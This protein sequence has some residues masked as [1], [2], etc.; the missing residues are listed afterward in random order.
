MGRSDSLL[1]FSPRFVF[2]GLA[3]P[4]FAPVLR[5]ADPTPTGNQELFVRGR[6]SQATPL[7]WRRTGPP[8]FMENPL[9]LCLAL[10]PR[11][12]EQPLP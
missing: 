7:E 10:R 8:T 4:L 1:S 12:T 6:P 2:L 3:I 9:C 5:F 11:R